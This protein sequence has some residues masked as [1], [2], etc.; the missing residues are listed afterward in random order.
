MCWFHELK[1][2]VKRKSSY[3]TRGAFRYP[4]PPRF[5]P[6][7]IWSLLRSFAGK[8]MPTSPLAWPSN[9]PHCGQFPVA[10][11]IALFLCHCESVVYRCLVL[12]L[13]PLI[14]WCIRA[15]SAARVGLSLPFRFHR[16]S[17]PPSGWFRWNF[18]LEAWSIENPC[19][20][21]KSLLI[22]RKGNCLKEKRYMLHMP[23]WRQSFSDFAFSVATKLFSIKN[24]KD[25]L[26]TWW[27]APKPISAKNNNN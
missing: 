25:T 18:L 16:R 22:W 14:L 23:A 20:I 3:Q 11:G 4:S 26:T 21:S 1:R 12:V 9:G 8:T 6:L 19:K 15:C 24:A 13:W 27:L 17:Q 7:K 2:W 10:C 5:D